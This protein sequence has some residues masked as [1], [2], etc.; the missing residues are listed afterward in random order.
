MHLGYSFCVVLELS[1]LAKKLENSLMKE[2]VMLPAQRNNIV[3]AML[4]TIR[5]AFF[6]VEI[7]PSFV[8]TWVTRQGPK[9]KKKRLNIV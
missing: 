7:Y 8:L 6:V 4:S 9:N 1:S 2:S 3:K 5:D